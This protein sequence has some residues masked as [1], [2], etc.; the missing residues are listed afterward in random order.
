MNIYVFINIYTYMY[1]YMLDTG[2]SDRWG[3]N[4]RKS[5]I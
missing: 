2:M 1:I 3:K 4:A 5:I